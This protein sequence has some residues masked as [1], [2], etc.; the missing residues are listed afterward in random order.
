MTRTGIVEPTAHRWLA[1]V[2]AVAIGFGLG[3]ERSPEDLE[4]WRNAQGGMAQLAEWAQDDSE[5]TDVRIRAIQI[6]IEEG[7][8]DRIPRTLDEIE[9]EAMRQQLADNALPT[10]EEMWEQQDFPE[11]TEEMQEEGAQIPIE[12]FAAVHAIDA[13]YR[14]HPYFGDDA[15]ETTSQILRDWISE[16]QELRT[17]LAETDIPF[18]IQYAGDDAIDLVTNWILEARDVRSV[19]SSLRRHAPDESQPTV[20]ETVAERAAEKHPGEITEDLQHAVAGATTDAIVPFLKKVVEDEETDE[21]FRQV[22]LDT[23]ADIDSD[24]AIEFLASLVEQERF[25]IRW[26]AANALIDARGAAGLTNIANS[27]PTDTDEYD[28]D[29]DDALYNRIRQICA[30]VHTNVDRGDIDP[31]PD[32]VAELLAMDR[33]PGHVLGLQCTGRLAIGDLREDVQQLTDDSFDI[34]AWGEPETVGEFATRVDTALDEGEE[35]EVAD[36]E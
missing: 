24:A 32:A 3:C 9:D 4:E 26:A 17:Q 22:A 1:I 6:L 21:M 31:D 23:A 8:S 28:F 15:Q 34:P 16:D 36:D 13:I 25:P 35:D 5:P 29:D 11:L 18:L 14:M 30:Y 27:L 12:D 2:I 20:D 19:A 33:W 7:E 10:I